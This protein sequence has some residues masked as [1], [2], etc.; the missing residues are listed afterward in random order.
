MSDVTANARA[1]QDALRAMRALPRLLSMMPCLILMP[2]LFAAA[3]CH[4]FSAGAIADASQID[5]LLSLRHLRRSP[6]AT[7]FSFAEIFAMPPRRSL[8][9]AEGDEFIF[10]RCYAAFSVMLISLRFAIIIVAI[11]LL[12]SLLFHARHYFEPLPF[13]IVSH[14]CHAADAVSLFLCCNT[15][16]PMRPPYAMSLYYGC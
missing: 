10:R 16:K 13:A 8:S 14:C 12:L 7:I 3:R 5:C 11:D 15:N 1:A 4:A 6:S 2:M 9:R